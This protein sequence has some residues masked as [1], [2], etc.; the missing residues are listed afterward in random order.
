MSQTYETQSQVSYRNSTVQVDLVEEQTVVKQETVIVY[1][2]EETKTV[3]VDGEVVESSTGIIIIGIAF[4]VLALLVML[5]CIRRLV[6]FFQHNW[7]F[8]ILL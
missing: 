7:L 8:C 5:F 2:P 4:A 6:H 3:K 1:S